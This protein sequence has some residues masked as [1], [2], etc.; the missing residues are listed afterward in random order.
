MKIEPIV[1][2]VVLVLGSLPTARAEG[3]SLH[4][5]NPFGNR[6]KTRETSPSQPTRPTNA[7]YRAGG[8]GPS[9]WTKLNRNVKRLNEGTKRFLANTANALCW[10]SASPPPKR[11]THSWRSPA[12]EK[13]SN[14]SWFKPFWSREEPPLPRTPQDFVGMERPRM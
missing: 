9:V 1:L 5:L 12:P 13:K 3:F 10:K 6:E 11:S 2:L 8:Q 4:D 14:T 7:S